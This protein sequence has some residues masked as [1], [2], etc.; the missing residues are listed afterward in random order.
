MRELNFY[1]L[2]YEVGAA[3]FHYLQNKSSCRIGIWA[4]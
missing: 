1:T 3:D 4:L 2:E